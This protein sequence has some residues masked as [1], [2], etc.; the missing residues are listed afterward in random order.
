MVDRLLSSKLLGP[1]LRALIV[2]AGQH[3]TGARVLAVLRQVRALG[4]QGWQIPALRRGQVRRE[5][6]ER[7]HQDLESLAE[8]PLI[9]LV[10]P[11]Y[12]TDQR[13]LR[14]AVESVRAQHYPGW[15]LIV[16][17]DGSGDPALNRTM[18]AFAASDP[19]IR[20]L[21]RAENAGISAATNAGLELC[22][23]EYVGFL[24]HDDT[25]TDDALLRFAQALTADPGLDVVY[26][27]S[28]KL[29]LNGRRADPFLKPDWSP[30][31]ALGAMY[32]GHLLVV[33][34]ELAVA[35]GGFDSAF[36]KIQDFEFLLRVSER[37]ERIAHIPEILYHWRAI[38][39]SIAAGAEEKSGVPELQARA[40]SQHLE[41]IGSNAEAVP[42]PTIPHRAILA[43]RNGAAAGATVSVVVAAPSGQP[44]PRRLLDSLFART[45]HPGL[46]VVLVAAATADAG[47]HP[48][49]RVEA[50]PAMTRAE[51]NN[52]G[53]AAASGS[54]LIFVDPGC[55]ILD[56]DW[57]DQLVLHAQAPGA[58]AAGPLLVRP[59]G[60][61]DQ[62]GIAIG[63]SEPAMPM[64]RGAD[65]EGDGYY[66]SLPCAREVSAVSSLC[67]LVRRE[68]FEA[69]GG[70]NEFFRSQ[71]ED[72]DLCQRLARAGQSTV[73]APRP[74]VVTRQSEA[75]RRE[76]T[77]IVDRALLVDCWYDE[78]LRG[79][80]YF[81][82]GFSRR[83]A[84][85]TPAGWRDRINRMTGGR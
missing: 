18:E 30:V 40:V 14:E 22:D 76:A 41:R 63:L 69:V 75:V 66:G 54:H 7:I 27:D 28:D 3:P 52:A 32:I 46:E 13:Y 37:T 82:P 42:H 47:E 20:F 74:R 81:N 56:A 5:A 60:R 31:Y 23:G 61:V 34:R 44:G 6:A 36:D 33:R 79:D 11:T 72:A 2:R 77:D 53:A 15:E 45:E 78:L 67:M 73:F 16:V 64:M 59:D 12:K 62:A 19:R 4:Q 83:E 35:A 8:Q 9:S 39:G 70:F 38:P 80:P 49:E 55:E 25:L 48:I 58:A 26:S 84:S 65:S 24:D 71:H 17:D 10:M 21:P 50:D 57:V 51:A 85:Y 1:R 29:D 68:A 43:P